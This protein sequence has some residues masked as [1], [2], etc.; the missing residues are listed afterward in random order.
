M[1]ISKKMRIRLKL[2]EEL[3]KEG[4]NKEQIRIKFMVAYHFKKDVFYRTWASYEW[5]GIVVNHSKPINHKKIKESLNKEDCC[6]F[7]NYSTTIEHHF[8]YNPER[9]VF[10]CASCHN[11][12]HKIQEEY[13]KEGLNKDRYIEL[14]ESSINKIR[15]ILSLKTP[16]EPPKEKEL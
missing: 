13:H 14:L 7:C 12:I 4:L 6:Y 9:T 1:G 10:I 5:G 15:E 11:K 8:S 16:Q 2:I 3:K